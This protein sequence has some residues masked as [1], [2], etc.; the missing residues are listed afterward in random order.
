MGDIVS[1]TVIKTLA[2]SPLLASV[3]GRVWYGPQAASGDPVYPLITFRRVVGAADWHAPFSEY[4][5][6][7]SAYS[8]KSVD[9]AWSLYDSCRVLLRDVCVT[10]SSGQSAVLTESRPAMEALDPG[11]RPV[12]RVFGVFQVRQ[13]G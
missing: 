3:E 11:G 6:V 13:L 7:I 10:G 8:E 12:Y 5:L 9:E 2:E 4:E 1:D